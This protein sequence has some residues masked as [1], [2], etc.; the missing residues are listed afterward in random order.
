[1]SFHSVSFNITGGP[2]WAGGG[3][4]KKEKERGKCGRKSK[5]S[6]MKVKWKE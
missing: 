1:L 2:F 3:I 4:E 6:K 5:K